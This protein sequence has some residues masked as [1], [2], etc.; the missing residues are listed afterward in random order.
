MLRGPHRAH[1]LCSNRR[2]FA[3]KLLAHNTF[4][5]QKYALDLC[6]ELLTMGSSLRFTK[7]PGKYAARVMMKSS[8]SAAIS[9]LIYLSF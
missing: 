8:L 4:M 1:G 2:S 9:T 7:A 6:F 3:V 5:K